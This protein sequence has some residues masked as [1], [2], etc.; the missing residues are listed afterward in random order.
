MRNNDKRFVTN[1]ALVLTA[2]TAGLFLI[3]AVSFFDC[4]GGARDDHVQQ[5]RQRQR[6]QQRQSSLS[7][8]NI[9]DE[10]DDEEEDRWRMGS[11]AKNEF[12][13]N[14]GNWQRYNRCRN[15]RS[16]EDQQR[17]DGYDADNV[18]EVVSDGDY[19]AYR[20]DEI[21][22]N[23]P[24]PSYASTTS[25]GYDV[26]C[27]YAKTCNGGLGLLLLF[28]FCLTPDGRDIVDNASTTSAFAKVIDSIA[29]PTLYWLLLISPTLLLQ[30]TLLFRMMGSSAD[31]YFSPSL[32]MFSDR[33]CLPPRFAG[34][35]L[36]A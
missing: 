23:T 20:C 32:T 35:T 34:V 24:L 29:I 10:D 18:T 12:T 4:R 36:L 30:L 15:R 27:R 1:M 33:L 21:Y 5:T 6:Q 16:L 17:Q 2:C 22:V 26:R 31:E 13:Y 3:L 11:L 14:N 8:Q 25:Y 19:S 28:V 7:Y 9:I